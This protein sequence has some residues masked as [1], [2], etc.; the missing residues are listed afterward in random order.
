MKKIQLSSIRDLDPELFESLSQKGS[1]LQ[2][3]PIPHTSKLAKEF[4]NNLNKSGNVGVY[5]VGANKF[6][7]CELFKEFGIFGRAVATEKFYGGFTVLSGAYFL[8]DNG[9]VLKI[10]RPGGSLFAMR[11]VHFSAHSLDEIMADFQKLQNYRFKDDD[12]WITSCDEIFGE[13]ILQDEEVVRII[14]QK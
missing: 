11:S 2:T 7:A 3:A 8:V 6:S 13:Y 9:S 12:S 14:S 5:A 10:T 1:S 4:L